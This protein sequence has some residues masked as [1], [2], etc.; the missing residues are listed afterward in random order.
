MQFNFPHFLSHREENTTLT[1]LHV[2]L[3]CVQFP[4]FIFTFFFCWQIYT[5]MYI[6]VCLYL[7]LYDQVCHGFPDLLLYKSA[8]YEAIFIHGR[9]IA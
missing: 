1:L 6:F 3:V 8:D 9:G 2:F 5:S 4:L 7:P